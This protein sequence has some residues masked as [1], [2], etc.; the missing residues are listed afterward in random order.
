R[1]RGRVAGHARPW[2][3]G[4]AGLVGPG[5]HT[6]L[7]RSR[8]ANRRPSADTLADRLPVGYRPTLDCNWSLCARCRGGNG[9]LVG[10]LRW[11]CSWAVDDLVGVPI[12]PCH[13]GCLA[14]RVFIC[15]C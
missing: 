3:G 5:A 13:V 2:L 10:R 8:N 9:G 11:T 14:C 12:Y 1:G 7:P 15:V 4:V 6:P